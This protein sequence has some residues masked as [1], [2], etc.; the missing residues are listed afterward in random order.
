[1][2]R[3]NFCV[4]LSCLTMIGFGNDTPLI[5]DH[6]ANHRV[7]IR[8]P[9]S[10]GR[11]RKGTF[12]VET[13]RLGGGHRLFEEVGDFLRGADFDVAFFFTDVFL[14][15]VLSAGIVFVTVF[16]LETFL[17]DLAIDVRFF[18]VAFPEER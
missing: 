5:D 7:G 18:L 15:I 1:V 12:H 2:K 11:Q 6:R 3:Q 9:L 13:I 16:F 4:G 14:R 10:P 8:L 17:V